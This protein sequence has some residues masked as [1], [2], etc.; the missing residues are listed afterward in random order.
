VPAAV[1]RGAP[2]RWD[3]ERARRGSPPRVP[4][5]FAAMC[6][7]GILI[8][9]LTPGFLIARCSGA[10]VARGARLSLLVPILAGLG[11]NF[12]I[13]VGAWPGRS[14]RCSS[15]G[16]TSAPGGLR[17]R[18]AA[19]GAAR[20]LFG[21][22]TG[23]LFNRAK[24]QMV[25][26]LIAG[27][28]ERLSDGVPVH[29][30]TVIP[31]HSDHAAAQATACRNTIDLVGIQYAT[32]TSSGALHDGRLAGAPAARDLRSSRSSVR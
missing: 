26:G 13:V 3:D 6:V 29:V 4:L 2:A 19:G 28:R 25:T 32:E 31:A 12:G 17:A 14:R 15:P 9:H 1:L 23:W 8:A 16:G 24:A 22:G 20:Q 5:L 7:R 18:G 11:L 30:G 27:L 10:S 21:A